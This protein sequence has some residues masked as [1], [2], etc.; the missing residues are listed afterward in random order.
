[1][2]ILWPLCRFVWLCSGNE[3]HLFVT[4][5]YHIVYVLD[6]ELYNMPLYSKSVNMK[7]GQHKDAGEQ[8]LS[9]NVALNSLWIFAVSSFTW[10]QWFQGIMHVT[11]GTYKEALTT[12][13]G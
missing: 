12:F 8:R 13:S 1:M 10:V 6:L 5:R 11:Q 2:P 9:V 4:G 3:D 7:C